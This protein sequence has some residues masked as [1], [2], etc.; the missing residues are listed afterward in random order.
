MEN[1][2]NW[3]DR[4]QRGKGKEIARAFFLTFTTHEEITKKI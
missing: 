4:I 2:E 1:K 3:L